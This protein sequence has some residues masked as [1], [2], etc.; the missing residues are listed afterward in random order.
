MRKEYQPVEIE[1]IH[2]EERD[3]ITGSNDLPVVIDDDD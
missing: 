3:I 1:I 2:F